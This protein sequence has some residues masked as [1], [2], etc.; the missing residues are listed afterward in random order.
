MS[1][2]M[3]LHIWDVEHGACTMLHHLE[4]NIAGRLAMIDSGSTP[5]W[6]PST[7]IKHQLNRSVLD[8]LFIT[9]ADQDH[10][11]DLDGLWQ[12]D[13][14]VK[15]LTRNPHP[16][17]DDLRKIKEIGGMS[18]D[19][20]RYL[21][22]HESYNNPVSEPFNDFMGGITKKTF[23]NNF[24]DFTDTNNLSCVV[25]FNFAG[26]KIIFPGDLEEE[27]WLSLLE[28]ESFRLELADVDVFVA[29]HH[30]RENGYCKEVFRYCSP[31][32][33]VMSDKSIIHST[34]EMTQTYRQRVNEVW[35]DG[36]LVETTMK[37]RRVLT[38][39]RDGWIQFRV[40]CNGEF[41]ITTEKLG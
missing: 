31:K 18:K 24:P 33:I 19:I 5:D 29:S 17:A 22:I 34:Q 26:F 25:F 7:F 15:T 39:R 11:S 13:I 16:N 30:G 36:V 27:G 35:P 41:T 4:N 12:E 37:R 2:E 40:N 6:R 21:Q 8:Y 14:N 23:H 10:L 3:I 9:N 20:E 28:N 32:V 38:T 1:G